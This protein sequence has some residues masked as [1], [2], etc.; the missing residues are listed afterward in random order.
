MFGNASHRSL[1]SSP[2]RG[3]LGG[4]LEFRIASRYL[5]GKKTHN[6]VNL[7]S[8]IAV[9]GIA[10]ATI[11]MVV[12]LSVF[13]GFHDLIEGLYSDFDPQLKLTPK[14]G[15]YFSEEKAD[16]TYEALAKRVEVAALSRVIEDEALILFRGHPQVITVKGVDDNFHK[17]IN[18]K[19]VLYGDGTYQL[20]RA[21]VEYAIPGVG[22]GQMMGGTSFPTLQICAPRGG[23]RINIMDPLESLSVAEV[24]NTGLM[25]SISQRKY[26]DHYVL[27][28]YN[29]AQTLFEKEGQ[30]TAIEIKAEPG[31]EETV[32]KYAE[33]FGTVK[34]RM[35]Q[36]EDIFGV[37]Q[38]EKLLAY[39]FLT[40]IFIVACFN[41]IS[42]VS[43]LILEKK[44]DALVLSH[45]G[46]PLK[47]VRNIFMCEG[48]IIT[49]SGTLIGIVIG[50]V[51]C[52]IQQFCGVIQ[53]G[54]GENFIV[55]DYP[56]SV[57]FIDLVLILLTALII[58]WL[59][60][61]YPVR[62]LINKTTND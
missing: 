25:F 7:I 17:V 51:L 11:A 62:R 38:I 41:I 33:H 15:K 57:H 43:M 50:T 47:R 60:T 1:N 37:M 61:W 35:E 26:D 24:S 22:I 28:S 21:D 42:S 16:S 55:Q 6:A 58:G 3:R 30:C 31:M 36:Q 52:L 44:D 4:G 20:H 27:I 18:I 19:D 34:N 9:G 10:M 46:M 45:I 8:G 56:V 23:E 39:V 59:A 29:L 13:N 48:Q 54:N 49:L 2:H 40:F 5:L 14:E 12:V 53:L 32:R